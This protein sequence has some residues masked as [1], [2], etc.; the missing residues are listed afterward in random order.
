VRGVVLVS[1]PGQTA[2]TRLRGTRRVRLG[3]EIDATDGVVDVTTGKD[4]RG[5][6]QTGRF[7]DGAFRI[8]QT[9]GSRPYTV[10]DLTKG[11]E[12]GCVAAAQAGGGIPAR[13]VT[14]RLWGRARGR[15]RTRG[16]RATAT[17]RGTT[18]TTEDTCQT[19]R[20]GAV[21][22]TV[23][24]TSGER[25][26]TVEDG[27]VSDFFCDDGFAGV[28][29]DFNFYCQSIVYELPRSRTRRDEDGP[30]G[31]LLFSLY[32]SANALPVP[33]AATACITNLRTGVERCTEYPFKNDCEEFPSEFCQLTLKVTDIC[34][35]PRSTEYAVRWRVGDV[36]L[37]LVQSGRTATRDPFFDSIF[38][39][40]KPC[41]FSTNDPLPRPA[42]MP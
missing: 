19:T 22:G 7:R 8:T 33:S 2:T 5:G 29:G 3:S 12:S 24:M 21:E 36:D 28:P 38:D 37:P 26:V 1:K 15:F 40:A 13:A 27:N 9:R 20:V 31:D 32:A 10:L 17:I 4:R 39:P 25:E 42:L 34:D 23:E 6:L 14:R 11:D 16:R 41:A 18:W 30:L 35:A